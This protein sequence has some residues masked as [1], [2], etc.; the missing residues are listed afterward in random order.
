MN[1][2]TYDDF[3]QIKNI[4]ASGIHIG[5]DA[6]A[7]YF[8]VVASNIGTT[9]SLYATN[10]GFKTINAGDFILVEPTDTTIVMEIFNIETSTNNV[11]VNN[12]EFR[13]L[14]AGLNI[15]VVPTTTTLLLNTINGT[16]P[17]TN[18][19]IPS[20]SVFATTGSTI[21]FKSLNAGSYIA[22][23]PTDTTLNINN[24][25]PDQTVSISS[26]NILVTGSY[27]SFAINESI[28]IPCFNT[29]RMTSSFGPW[30][31]GL[32][33]GGLNYNSAM[34][35]ATGG[36]TDLTMYMATDGTVHGGTIFFQD[37]TAVAPRVITLMKNGTGTSLQFTIA[38]DAQMATTN[39]TV[40]FVA[41]DRLA[42]GVSNVV[43]GGTLINNT[44]LSTYLTI[45]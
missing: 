42:W 29:F 10:L 11:I 34:G 24:S 25:A 27:P 38:T 19:G 23:V 13:S 32:N 41:G 21:D 15:F 1:I 16:L 40:S 6:S 8:S 12:L 17:P 26:S 33:G 44:C 39:T 28:K 22:I 4:V 9:N 7:L 43:A 30:Y 45:Q 18:V 14:D 5:E 31:V 20:Y 2:V 36:N 37:G 3:L 35:A